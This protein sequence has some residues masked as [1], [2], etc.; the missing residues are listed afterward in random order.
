MQDVPKLG[1]LKSCQKYNGLPEKWLQNPLSGMVKIQ[2][3]NYN[4]GNNN[5]YPEE[6]SL[7]NSTR[8]I[9][10]FYIDTTEVTNA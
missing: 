1:S 5:A 4:I 8:K 6:K 3:G 10:D 7:L 9:A 2:G